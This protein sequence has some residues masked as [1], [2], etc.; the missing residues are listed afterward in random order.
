MQV[1]PLGYVPRSTGLHQFNG[2]KL[3]KVSIDSLCGFRK[4]ISKPPIE[5]SILNQIRIDGQSSI[6]LAQRSA[7]STLQSIL[8]GTTSTSWQH[9]NPWNLESFSHRQAPS[10]LIRKPSRSPMLWTK[11][12]THLRNFKQKTGK[13][14]S[15]GIRQ[16]TSYGLPAP[17]Q[18]PK[19]SCSAMRT[20]CLTRWQSSMR[21]L[22]MPRMYA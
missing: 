19:E 1:A 18:I 11:P 5:S 9:S 20:C 14:N 8:D 16:Q 6:W 17:P 4:I 10:F 12:P 3:A 15:G 2:A 7:P 13:P 22:K 21:C